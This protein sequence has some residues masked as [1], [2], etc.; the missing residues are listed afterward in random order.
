[1]VAHS[2]KIIFVLAALISFVRAGA[3][4]QPTWQ[5]LTDYQDTPTTFNLTA[6]IF[7]PWDDPPSNARD[8]TIPEVNNLPDL[9]GD[10]VDPQ[11]VIYF[12][13]N[14][15]MMVPKLI[16]EFQKAHPKY[17]HILYVTLPP[18][19]LVQALEKHDGAFAIGNL[20]IALKPDILTRGKGGMTSLQNK[21][22]WFSKLE[23]Y[24]GNTLALMVAKD[25]PRHVNG[26]ADLADPSLRISMPNPSWEGIATPI[27]KAYVK[28]GGEALK[29][30]VMDTKKADGTTY[31]T[32]IHHRQTPMRIM[33]GLADVGPVWV[34]EAKYQSSR[35][36]DRIGMVKIP[37]AQNEHVTYTA[38]SLKDAPHPEAAKAFMD[39]LVS[40][41]GQKVITEYGFEPAS[42][43]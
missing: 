8:F 43:Q 19:I 37:E 14:Q 35:N 39:F 27:Q 22:G 40:K 3:A 7:P 32:H 1:M 42:D 30:A 29:T 2:S 6:Q 24:A 41:E 12:A 9:H 28:A 11:L 17:Q 13:G 25:N 26:L 4:E 36:G 18:G 38:G 31:L 5:S 23:D 21:K 16:H 20:R 34:T 10:I 15:Y 33:A